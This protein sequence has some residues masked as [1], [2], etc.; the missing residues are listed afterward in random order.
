MNQIFYRP[1]VPVFEAPRVDGLPYMQET[2]LGFSGLIRL[3][4]K[5]TEKSGQVLP[6]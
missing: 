1:V 3:C 4:V 5:M 6:P 2:S